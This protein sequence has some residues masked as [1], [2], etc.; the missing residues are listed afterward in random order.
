V[1]RGAW[2]AVLV[3]LLGTLIGTVLGQIVGLALPEG[4]LRG[5]FLAGV[6]LGLEEP[7]TLDL[8]VLRLTFGLVFR[9]NPMTVA[10]LLLAAFFVYRVR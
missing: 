9:I 2:K 3:L 1:K 10:G 5:L 4:P 7:F 6:S 8:S